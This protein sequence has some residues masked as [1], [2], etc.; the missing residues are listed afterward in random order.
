M[1]DAPPQ[2]GDIPQY[3]EMNIPTLSST[4]GNSANYNAPT[5]N[6][7]SAMENVKATVYNSE[8]AKSLSPKDALHTLTWL[9]CSS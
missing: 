1:S 4:N 6:G 9:I 7:S 5:A 2:L 8:V 3:S